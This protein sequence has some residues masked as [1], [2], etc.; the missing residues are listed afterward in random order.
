MA[1]NIRNRLGETPNITKEQLAS[2]KRRKLVRFV[3]I[4]STTLILLA[5]GSGI[6]YTWY[7]GQQDNSKSIAKPQAANKRLSVKRPKV[8]Q[9]APV[10]VSLQSISNP[11]SIA[12][13]SVI[14]IQTNPLAKCTIVVNY[15]EEAISVDSGLKPKTADDFGVVSWSWT[16]EPNV[17]RGNY[18]VET[19]CKNKKNSG[20][21]ISEFT[22]E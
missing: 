16:I 2:R 11:V 18:K 5:V 7:V 1:R 20:V 10:G 21:L 14:S 15:G 12:E 6:L 3:I 19:T 8:S 22:V 4:G 13:N 9:I 17:A